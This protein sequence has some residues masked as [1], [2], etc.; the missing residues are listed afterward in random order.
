MP[1]API[2][3]PS[4]RKISRKLFLLLLATANGNQSGSK[5]LPCEAYLFGPIRNKF[6]RTCVFSSTSG[7]PLSYC[8]PRWLVTKWGG[9]AKAKGTRGR[10]SSRGH[11]FSW[12][13]NACC[14]YLLLRDH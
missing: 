10:F 9:M 7:S 4:L 3:V 12:R 11:V 14:S 5:K 6:L 1:R 8:S 2:R 13:N